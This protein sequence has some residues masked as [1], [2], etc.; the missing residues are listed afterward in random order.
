MKG[1]IKK[2]ESGGGQ[3]ARMVHIISLVS[4]QLLFQK[5]KDMV[6]V[7]C[8]YGDNNVFCFY[9]FQ[10]GLRQEA[11]AHAF[12]IFGKNDRIS[13]Q[14]HR[15]WLETIPIQ[16]NWDMTIHGD[17]VTEAKATKKRKIEK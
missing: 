12:S 14:T 2:Q 16:S 6:F 5:P 9:G 8:H 3:E 4:P 13:T 10:V 1:M 17:F 15:T 7:E 11:H